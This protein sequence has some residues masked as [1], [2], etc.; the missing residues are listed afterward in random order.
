MHRS[1]VRVL[2]S[3]KWEKYEREVDESVE[4]AKVHFGFSGKISAR[5]VK[6]RQ[7]DPR[8]FEEIRNERRQAMFAFMWRGKTE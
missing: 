3:N 7:S 6:W 2:T 8:S 5:V 1:R 4:V